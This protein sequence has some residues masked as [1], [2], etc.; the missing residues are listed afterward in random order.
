MVSVGG[1]LFSLNMWIVIIAIRGKKWLKVFTQIRTILGVCE[2]WASYLN[3]FN[4]LQMNM[5]YFLEEMSLKFSLLISLKSYLEIMS[6]CTIKTRIL[7]PVMVD[8][9]IQKNIPIEKL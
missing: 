7:L 9:I 5:H 2:I 1:H 4:S 3:I 6:A 8:Q